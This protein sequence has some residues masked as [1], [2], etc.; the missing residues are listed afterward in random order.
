M[1]TKLRTPQ[2]TGQ[3][4]EDE[5]SEVTT[6][7]IIVREY[8][9]SDLAA[10]RQL[11]GELA[12]HH[13]EIY[14]DPSI[15]G[16]DPGRGLD[17]YLERGERIGMWVAERGNRVVGFAGLLDTVG[18]ESVAEIEPL[19]V[20]SSYRSS[21]VG[22]SLVDEAAEEAKRRGF[23]FLVIRPELR[24]TE[25]F[26]LYVRLGFDHV[27]AIE[28]FKELDSHSDRQWKSGIRIHGQELMY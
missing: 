23:R 18:E 5:A 11:W 19:V 7:K 21:G 15:A 1:I 27:G 14:D 2:R 16:E 13:A 26:A 22:T 4:V 17:D 28:L 9:E 12:R 24:N 25:A 10:C 8:L 3:S 20:E 6:G